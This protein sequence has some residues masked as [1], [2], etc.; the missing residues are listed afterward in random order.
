M[1]P[2]AYI[3][4][5][6]QRAPWVQ[7]VQ[8]EQ[9]LVISRALVELF[10]HS[11]ISESLAFRGG[12]ALHKLHLD[13]A[14]YSEDIDLV[15][16]PQ[17]AIGETIDAVREALSPWLGEA[18]NWEQKHARFI[19]WYEVESEPEV[20]S[21][22]RLEVEVN[23]REHFTVDGF[24]TVDF[25]V[26]SPWFTGETEIT[27]YSLEELLG[28]K[29]RALYQRDKGR[30]LFDLWYAF[31]E[32]DLSTDEVVEICLEYLE[33]GGNTVSRAEFERNL[34]EKRADDGFRT[35]IDP[36]LASRIDWSF[37]VALDA[38]LENYI[39]RFPGEAWKGTPE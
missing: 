24:E 6:R 14:R 13:P 9:D 35:D 4:Q 33:H 23:T 15:Q 28:T 2:K 38:V 16:I 18:V 17:E 10:E 39:A 36:L 12:T 22:I 3:T 30:D 21:P 34:E 32:C 26:E 11:E 8:V 19:W 20:A 25:E 5:W 29:L 27:T 7:D 31:E 1:I 37:D